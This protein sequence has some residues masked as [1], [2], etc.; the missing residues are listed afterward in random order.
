MRA[1]CSSGVGMLSAR[2]SV[3]VSTPEWMYPRCAPYC[4]RYHTPSSLTDSTITCVP[5]LSS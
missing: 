4:T 5:R 3:S 2:P 1:P